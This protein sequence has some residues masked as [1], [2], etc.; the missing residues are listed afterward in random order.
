[1]KPAADAKIIVK[2]AAT[3]QGGEGRPLSE[4]AAQNDEQLAKNF[5]IEQSDKDLAERVL[6]R[7]DALN[8]QS[9]PDVPVT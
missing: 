7:F 5:P 1:M 3:L 6:A 4:L 9:P 8:G 2:H